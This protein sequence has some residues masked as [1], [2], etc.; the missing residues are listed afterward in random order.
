MFRKFIKASKCA[1]VPFAG[2]CIIY[3]LL[4]V[5]KNTVVSSSNA[6]VDIVFLS[7]I[8]LIVIVDS[9]IND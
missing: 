2:G 7:L 5:Y 9:T 6:V 4:K 3:D 8:L 1:F